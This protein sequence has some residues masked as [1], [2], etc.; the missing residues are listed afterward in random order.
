MAEEKSNVPG[1]ADE[2]RTRKTVKMSGLDIAGGAPKINVNEL[3]QPPAPAPAP[4]QAPASAP[5]AA[6]PAS[7]VTRRTLKLQNLAK[8]GAPAPAPAPAP[9][10]APAAAA[11]PD[12][13]TRRT[14][15]LSSLAAPKLDLAKPSAT[16]K[17]APAPAPNAPKQTVE[18]P[19]QDMPTNTRTRRTQKLE[20]LDTQDVAEALTAGDLK[21][22]EEVPTQTRRTQKLNAETPGAPAIDL[23]QAGSEP[24]RAKNVDDTVKLQRPAPKPTMP[25]SVTPAAQAAPAAPAAGGIKLTM[26]KPPPKPAVAPAPTAPA[27]TAQP[28]PTGNLGKDQTPPKAKAGLK[29]NTNALSDLGSA[30]MLKGE[31]PAQA[32]ARAKRSDSPVVFGVWAFFLSVAALFLIF[33]TL[34]TVTDYFSIWRSG[35]SNQMEIPIVSDHVAKFT[36]FQGAQTPQP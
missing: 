29:V 25:G 15:K 27:P 4:A 3:S 34:V 18:L 22:P 11:A 6:K 12:T 30:P 24:L 13:R 33:I 21:A 14:V 10:P 31:H 36:S 19:P 26:P 32:A 23:S 9:V 1:N 35:K 20:A 16:V 8:L 17:P 7:T 5:A 28:Q 2:T